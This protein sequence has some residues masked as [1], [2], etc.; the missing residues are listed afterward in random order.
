MRWLFGQVMGIEMPERLAPPESPP[1]LD[2]SLYEGVFERLGF[3]TRISAGEGG[4]TMETVNTKPLA[5]EFQLPP[6]P[7]AA[8]D[9]ER[10]LQRDPWG[11]WQ[12][13][14]FSEFEAGR[15][16]YLYAGRVARRVDGP[17]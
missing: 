17:A 2:L 15:P 14:V 10:F 3:R 13:V 16:R 7:L 12:P 5:E 9:A 1:E 6:A 8:V 11:V 4:L